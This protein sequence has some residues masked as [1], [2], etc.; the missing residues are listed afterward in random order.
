[1]QVSVLPPLT[2]IHLGRLGGLIKPLFLHYDIPGLDLQSTT[3]AT[4]RGRSFVAGRQ[5]N[6]GLTHAGGVISSQANVI[7]HTTV[8]TTTEPLSC[9]TSSTLG[10]TACHSPL[11]GENE[12]AENNT[13][14]GIDLRGPNRA[15][16]PRGAAS[17]SGRETSFEDIIFGLG[18]GKTPL[19]FQPMTLAFDGAGS[20]K[21]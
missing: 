17:Q 1:V 6:L 15:T 8:S 12:A 21:A 10:S 14:E 19:G 2:P 3:Q 20:S 11:G 7:S 16:Y 18:P 5:E 13:V 4:P 9:H